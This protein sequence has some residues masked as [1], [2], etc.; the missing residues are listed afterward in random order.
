MPETER[1]NETCDEAV[2]SCGLSFALLHVSPLAP[3]SR[4]MRRLEAA[5]LGRKD[6]HIS[7]ERTAAERW[8]DQRAKRVRKKVNARLYPAPFSVCLSFFH[9]SS[10]LEDV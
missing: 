10:A 6:D 4:M 2:A 7:S 8:G 9:F 5:F 3:S 1:V